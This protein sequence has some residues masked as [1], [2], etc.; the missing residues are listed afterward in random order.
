MNAVSMSNMWSRDF[1]LPQGMR[2]GF[3]IV[4]LWPE[5][6]TAEDECIA[7]LKIAAEALGLFCF[8]I[9]ADGRYLEQPDRVLRR[10]E[11]DFVL[12]LH[13]DTP[14]LYDA[15]SIVAL[16]NPLAFYHEWGYARTSRNLLTH[17]DFISCSSQSADDHV[18]RLVRDAP[19]HLPPKF[20]LYHSTADIVHPPSLGDFKL[21]Y[22]G[23]NWEAIGRGQSRHQ[24]V[25]KRLDQA[26][27]VRIFGP[28][29]FMGVKVW[30]GYRNY[31]RGIPFDGISMIHEIHNAGIALVLSS[32]AHKAA[33][34]MSNRLFES[35]AAGALVIC[36]ENAFA[37]KFF[38]DSLLYIDGRCSVEQ[39]FSDIQAHIA[40]VKAHPELALAM[41]EKA[42]AIF[43][44]DFNLTKN[45]RD[46]FSGLHDRQAALAAHGAAAQP[47]SSSAVPARAALLSQAQPTPHLPVR[48]HLL[49]PDFS[50]VVLER[51]L[52]NAVCQQYGQLDIILHVDGAL[53]ADIR[54][55]IDGRIAQTGG[56]VQVAVARYYA[57]SRHD[58]VERRRTGQVIDDILQDVGTT[59]QAGA[60]LF[61]APNEMLL[62]N[63]VALL[64]SS[65]LRHPQAPCAASAV[66][67]RNGAAPV[68]TVGDRIEFREFS[69]EQPV[70]YARFMMRVSALAADRGLFLPY[71]DR[72]SMAVLSGGGNIVQEMLSTVSIHVDQHFPTG[73]WNEGQ[74]NELLTSF[75]P[76]V[77]DAHLGHAIVLPPLALPP[78]V[79]APMTEKPDHALGW[80]V[81]QLH[82]LERDGAMGRIK[83]FIRRIGRKFS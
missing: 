56:I 61:V 7:R 18:A 32:A 30:A 8:E 76:T 82:L 77:F 71:L 62:S 17:D 59:A 1:A 60:V 37:K 55:H 65:L 6:K 3:A 57:V 80:L 43:R 63:H 70:G 48:M 12:H 74:E 50:E 51:H 25:L 81:F 46:L 75:T 19:T 9:H 2:G 28:E 41:I 16:W 15:F 68:N 14:K 79:R 31:V 58:V 44:A 21:F 39:I 5:I 47:V 10:E 67:Y 49:M 83:A 13:Y 64:A 36:D 73:N 52:H 4:K 33:A 11:V 69:I 24:E 40:W 23:I 22:A 53:P 29:I 45:L 78:G 34:L 72:K 38:G 66:L 20:K 26:D 54:K 35:I 27:A 42:Q